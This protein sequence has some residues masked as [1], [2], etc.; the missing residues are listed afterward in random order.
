[1]TGLH[2]TIVLKR[3]RTLC[4][5]YMTQLPWNL[6]VRVSG[7][8]GTI[9]L[10][11]LRAVCQVN[12]TKL[13]WKVGVAYARFSWQY[14]SKT[15]LYRVPV[16]RDTIALKRLFPLCQIYVT[17][18]PLS[19][20]SI[21]F[22]AYVTQSPLNVCV[23]GLRLTWQYFTY[24]VSLTCFQASALRVSKQVPVSKQVFNVFPSKCQAIATQLH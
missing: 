7:F 17:I 1:M 6:G 11:H 12:T 2:D 19:C 23:P 13:P 8:R 5:F 9:A 14:F 22:Q 16:L 24:N 3:P 21:V 10:K 15:S 20:L 4:Q 18:F